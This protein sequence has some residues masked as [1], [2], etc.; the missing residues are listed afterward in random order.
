MSAPRGYQLTSDGK[1]E[2]GDSSTWM[3][4]AGLSRCSGSQSGSRP[5]KESDDCY[6]D[7]DP[8]SW[9]FLLHSP[10]IALS[11]CTFSSEPPNI[12]MLEIYADIMLVNSLAIS[13]ELSRKGGHL[14]IFTPFFNSNHKSLCAGSYYFLT[15]SS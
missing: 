15:N 8:I 6:P 3:K 5:N 9:I 13:S 2:T 12:E 7:L 1:K 4:H 14:P 10:V 11:R